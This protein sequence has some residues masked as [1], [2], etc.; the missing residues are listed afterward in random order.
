MVRRFF[1]FSFLSFLIQ[2][3]LYIQVTAQS[4]ETLSFPEAEGFG[5]FASGG[6][7]GVVLHVNDLSDLSSGQLYNTSGNMVTSSDD[8]AYGEGTLRWAIEEVNGPRYVIFDIGGVTDLA[9]G[10]IKIE[11]PYITIA[12]QTA[13]GE[14]IS[15]RLAKIKVASNDI[16]IRGMRLRPDD[17]DGTGD[18]PKDRDA[19]SMGTSG[20]W[21]STYNIIIDHNSMSWALDEVCTAIYGAHDITISYNIIAEAL[22]DN[23]H[24]DEGKTEPAPHGFL[25]LFSEGADR[26]SLTKNL[27]STARAR[28]PQFTK[29][30]TN[31]EV[32]KNYN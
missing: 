13:P 25:V 1:T 9:S 17:E 26:I 12:G 11:N 32:I 2:F 29:D 30:V 24:I 5:R 16:I 10:Q 31:I 15:T 22:D 28:F 14:G 19:L 8:A 6:R 7:G 18:Q 27:L 21:N 4:T 23:I 20:N 3:I